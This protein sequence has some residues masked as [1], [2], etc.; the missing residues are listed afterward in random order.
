M[1]T[2]FTWLLLCTGI[3][4]FAQIQPR[5]FLLGGDISMQK[6]LHSNGD[7]FIMSIAP[8]VGFMQTEHW[9]IGAQVGLVYNN[10]GSN[11]NS[12][13]YFINPF[14][15]YYLAPHARW[16]LFLQGAYNYYHNK[17]ND[18]FTESITSYSQLSLGAGIDYFLN[19]NIAIEGIL[20]YQNIFGSGAP[21]HSL[22]YNTGLQFFL[23]PTADAMDESVAV[24]TG[25]RLIGLDAS[26]A[27]INF[28]NSDEDYSYLSIHPTL[29]YFFTDRLVAGS[30][31]FLGFANDNTILE[32]QPFVR[33]YIGSLGSLFQPFV[34]A[35]LGT[36]FQFADK[37][38][39]PGFFNLSARIGAGADYFLTPVVALE[40]Q[41][42]YDG[43]QIEDK[44]YKY[45]VLNFNIGFQF[46]LK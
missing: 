28:T 37:S 7:N 11:R 36:R 14:L 8:L 30:G 16:S 2:T 3:S 25:S 13:E 9:M 32:P 18:P 35:Q 1:K 15:R 40:G 29:G 33:Y 21:S 22:N 39:E 43:S 4:L 27:W 38:S 34:H 10:Y 6:P 5:S 44:R 20:Q 17:F 24:Q 45:E 42:F 31:L 19:T 46:F 12:N 26:G 41:L 23:P